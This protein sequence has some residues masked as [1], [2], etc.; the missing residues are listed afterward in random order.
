MSSTE[1]MFLVNLYFAKKNQ[2]IQNIVRGKLYTMNYQ[3][4]MVKSLL[5]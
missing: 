1:K 4:D 3:N 2:V 5:L